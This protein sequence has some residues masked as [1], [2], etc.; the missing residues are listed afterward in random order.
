MARDL[1][2]AMA[3]KEASLRLSLDRS[4][5]FPELEADLATY[6]RSLPVTCGLIAEQARKMQL[7]RPFMRCEVLS[8]D[9]TCFGDVAATTRTTAPAGTKDRVKTT[10]RSM[11]C[12]A[13]SASVQ[14]PTTLGHLVRLARACTCMRSQSMS[15]GFERSPEDGRLKDTPFSAPLKNNLL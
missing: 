5:H 2:T 11:S 12:L 1:L 6:D 14:E 9:A 15:E 3:N 4:G 7:T 10:G 13:S 8:D